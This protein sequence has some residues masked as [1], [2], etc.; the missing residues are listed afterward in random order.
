MDDERGVKALGLR[1]ALRSHWP[2]YLIEAWALGMFMISAGAFST[3]LEFP[4]SPAQRFVPNGALRRVL[5]GAAMGLTAAALICSPWGKRSGAHMNPAVTL[6]F[7]RL[8]R[9]ARWDATFYIL[10][11][12]IGGLCGVLVVTGLLRDACTAPPVQY[13]VTSPGTRGALV[14]FVAESLI[15]ALLM[16]VILRVSNHTRYAK[17]TGICAGVMVALFIVLEA[18]F[19]GMSMNP[20]RSFASALPAHLWRDLWVYFTAPLLGMQTAAAWYV[21]RRGKGAVGC[22]KL[23]HPPEQPCIH[24]GYTPPPHSGEHRADTN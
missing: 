24:C 5:V 4:G 3:L 12:F 1:A 7:W 17:F 23:L 20:A 16:S 19:S 8:G 9:I 21:C 18:P 14:A 22:A 11:Q 10:A 13:A 2:E 15:S 6:T